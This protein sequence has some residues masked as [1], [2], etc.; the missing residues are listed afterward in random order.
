MEIADVHFQNQN[1]YNRLKTLMAIPSSQ[2]TEEHTTSK[3]EKCDHQM[4]IGMLTAEQNTKKVKTTA[5]LPTFSNAVSIKEF[6]KIILSLKINHNKPSERV[7]TWAAA[8]N[9]PDITAIDIQTIKK[10]L[11]L[12]Q[13]SLREIEQNADKLCSEHLHSMLTEAEMN[14]DEKTIERRLKILIR[15]HEQKQHY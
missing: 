8:L 15:A 6:L 7:S 11:W 2:W 5:W 3:Y 1:L 9:I 12:A 13:K 14:R 10:E 4:I